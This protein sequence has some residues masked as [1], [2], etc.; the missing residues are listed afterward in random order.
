M[1]N[2]KIRNKIPSL[3][4]L[5]LAGSVLLGGKCNESKPEDV[6]ESKSKDEV[7]KDSGKGGT[8]TVKPEEGKEAQKLSADLAA[9]VRKFKKSLYR[10][11]KSRS[12]SKQEEALSCE[13]G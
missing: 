13:F 10:L 2:K 7:A 5:L 9:A 4:S 1:V 12:L 11:F 3:S 6:N 8:S